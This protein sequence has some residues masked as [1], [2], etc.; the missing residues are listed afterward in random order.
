MNGSI[1]L[2]STPSVGSTATFEVPFKI[3]SWCRN[4]WPTSLPHPTIGFQIASPDVSSQLKRDNV[5][6]FSRPLAKRSMTSELLN[7]QIS[8]SVTNYTS[9]ISRG[10]KSGGMDAGAAATSL[11]LEQRKSVHILVVEDKY[12]SM[13]Y[14]LPFTLIPF[15]ILL[16]PPQFLP[17][18]RF[19]TS[20]LMMIALST[21]Q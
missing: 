4:P 19:R 15:N 7:Q 16:S 1:S 10:I 8:S 18:S 9:P 11:S 17:L 21:K 13:L 5:S 3:A 12:V 20:K 14:I 6:R 2:T